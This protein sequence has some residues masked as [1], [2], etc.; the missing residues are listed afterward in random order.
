MSNPLV[1]AVRLV[2]PDWDS[3]GQAFLPGLLGQEIEARST[4][5][6]LAHRYTASMLTAK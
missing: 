6:F 5:Q 1:R 4:C 3:L 2:Y